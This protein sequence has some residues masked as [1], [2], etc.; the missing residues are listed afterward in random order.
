[1]LL[2][3]ID[4]GLTTGYGLALQN[5]YNKRLIISQFGNVGLLIIDDRINLEYVRKL[6][7]KEIFYNDKNFKYSGLD[8]LPNDAFLNQIKNRCLNE[9]CGYIIQME[10]FRLGYFHKMN[11][12]LYLKVGFGYYW[13]NG[14]AFTYQDPSTNKIYEVKTSISKYEINSAIV[15]YIKKI[16][17][18]LG[19]EFSTITPISIKIILK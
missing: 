15:Y 12:K 17:V 7:G 11:E 4:L 5:Y 10:G 16:K 8:E 1:M 14:E 3:V 6:D 9:G 13:G 18:G 2:I 19:F